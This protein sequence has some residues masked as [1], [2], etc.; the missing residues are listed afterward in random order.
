M[1]KKQYLDKKVKK[2]LI[3]SGTILAVYVGMKYLLPLFVPFIIAYFFAWILRPIVSWLRRKLK[4]PLVFGGIVCVI[5][6]TSAFAILLFY[7]G[8]V[9]FNQLLLFLRNIPAYLQFLS[10]ELEG[11][12]TGCDR[13]FRLQQG[14]MREIANSGMDTLIVYVQEN[15]MPLLTVQTIKIAIAVAGFLTIYLIVLIATVLFIK[16][17]EEY[18]AGLRKSEFYPAVHKVTRKLSDTGIAYLK[19]Q[20]ILMTII[21]SIITIGFTLIKNPYALL[22]GIFVGIFDAFPVLGSG[23]ILVPWSIIMVLEKR[24]IVAAVIMT[25]FVLCQI[26]REILEPR[27]LGN[28]I[29][30]KP[31]YDMMA[32]YVGVRLFGVI[33]FFLGPL[34]LEIIKTVLNETSKKV[35]SPKGVK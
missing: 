6:L 26:V 9:L 27:L 8:R 13:L 21:A 31:I 5:I 4:V 33:G 20:L 29:G 32:M 25:I 10:T 30:I 14:T 22:I 11:L 28:K 35:K 18:K 34:S 23:L 3:L 19:T 24:F 7:L 2:L 12:C 1:E 16:D 17:M 15:V